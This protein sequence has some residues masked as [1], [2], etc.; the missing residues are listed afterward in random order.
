MRSSRF[1][2]ID[3]AGSER[4]KLTNAQGDRL[5]EAGAI[6]KSLT[7]LGI[8]IN[9]LVEISEGKNRHVH[10][11]DSKLTYLL[12]DS[13]GGNSKTLIIA[14]VTPVATSAG[15]TLSTLQFA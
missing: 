12:R 13:L 6:N 4:N 2:I 3:L 11:R 1:H 9:S 14:N 10:Y 7:A 5:K 8:V 15:E